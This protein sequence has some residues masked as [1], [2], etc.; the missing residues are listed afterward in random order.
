MRPS[1]EAL[2]SGTNAAVTRISPTQLTSKDCA[3][4]ASSNENTRVFASTRMPALLTSTSSWPTLEVTHSAQALTDSALETSSTCPKTESFSDWRVLTVASTS[5]CLRHVTITTVL[6]PR[7][8]SA[9][10]TASPI[11]RFAPV[12]R[13]TRGRCRSDS[14]AARAVAERFDM[15]RAKPPSEPTKAATP[16]KRPTE[17]N[18]AMELS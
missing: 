17:E 7:A 2:S 6:G 14:A 1:A 15:V 4:A 5:S 8:P 18:A 12:T 9:R 3:I 11:P 13:H 10:A 16:A